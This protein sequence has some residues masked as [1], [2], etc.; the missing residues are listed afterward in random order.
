MLSRSR[1]FC[2]AQRGARTM[3]T[4]GLTRRVLLLLCVA[5]VLLSGCVSKSKY[6]ALLEQY[7]ELAG[8]YHQLQ[9]H[10]AATTAALAAT[11]QELAAD[12]AHIGRLQDAIKYTVNSD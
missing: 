3:M 5:S 7:D 10:D 12:R 11:Q 2:T 8:H 6:H 9:E 1:G 4:L